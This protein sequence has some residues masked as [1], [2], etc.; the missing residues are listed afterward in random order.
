MRPPPAAQTTETAESIVSAVPNEARIDPLSIGPLTLVGVS[1]ES[2]VLTERTFLW[3][4]T[5]WTIGVPIA[6]D[7][8]LAVRAAPLQ[9]N[10]LQWQGDHEPCDWMWPTSRW[11]PGTIYCD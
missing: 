7:L 9:P 6:T 2:T 11:T 10:G 5:Y 8:M 3:L 1:I 4:Y